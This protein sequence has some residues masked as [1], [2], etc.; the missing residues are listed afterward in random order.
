MDGAVVPPSWSFDPKRPSTGLCRLLGGARPWH[1]HGDSS[2]QTFSG[3]SATNVLIPRVSH[4]Q[5]PRPAQ[6]TCR[7]HRLLRPGRRGPSTRETLC[8]LQERSPSPQSA[9][10]PCSGPA[11]L[12]RRGSPGNARAPG[13]GVWRGAPNACGRSFVILISSL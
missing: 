1:Q 9:R 10:L 7:T 3:A 12:H 4:G 8:A 13:W 6:E 2:P 5:P 11:G